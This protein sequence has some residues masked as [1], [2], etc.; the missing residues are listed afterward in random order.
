MPSPQAAALH[1]ADPGGRIK[2]ALL[3]GGKIAAIKLCRELTPGM[4]LAD[5]K[6]SVDRLQAELPD[7][8][9]RRTGGAGC[10][11]LFLAL[12]SGLWGWSLF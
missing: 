1:H 7:H 9:R 3:G 12:A 4:S 8:L 6:E 2:Q 5:A 11:L 10:L